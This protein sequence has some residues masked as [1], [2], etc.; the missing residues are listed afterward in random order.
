MHGTNWS[1]TGNWEIIT[2]CKSYDYRLKYSISITITIIKKHY[3]NEPYQRT[4]KR[5]KRQYVLFKLY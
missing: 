5:F 1:K 4:P 2:I 3:G